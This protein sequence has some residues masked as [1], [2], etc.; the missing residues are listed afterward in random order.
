MIGKAADSQL[1][2]LFALFDYSFSLSLCTTLVS[3][4]AGALSTLLYFMFSNC[5][6]DRKRKSMSKDGWTD[7]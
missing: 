1:S 3:T 5:N 7:K 2:H 6:I 4:D